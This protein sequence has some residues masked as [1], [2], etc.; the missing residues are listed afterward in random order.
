VLF[1]K[2]K[3]AAFSSIE[4]ELENVSLYLFIHYGREKNHFQHFLW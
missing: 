3:R 4:V 1:Q 2:R